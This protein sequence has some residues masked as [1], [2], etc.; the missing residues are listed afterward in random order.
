MLFAEAWEYIRRI[1]LLEVASL[2]QKPLFKTPGDAEP[3]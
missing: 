1:R 3:A 2:K